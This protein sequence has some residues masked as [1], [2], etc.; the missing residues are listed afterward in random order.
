MQD[1]W[2]VG[3]TF[4]SF[5]SNFFT[6]PFHYFQI[7]NLVDCLTGFCSVL[8]RQAHG[9]EFAN[10]IVSP[11]IRRISLAYFKFVFPTCWV[12]QLKTSQCLWSN[13]HCCRSQ[14]PH[15]LRRGSEAGRLLGLRVRIPPGRRCLSLVNVLCCQ[16][17]VSATGR[18]V[19]QGSPTHWFFWVWSGTAI[20]NE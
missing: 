9:S 19:V 15:G 4:G 12:S 17:E 11:R 3:K 13:S 7:V 8:P 1:L 18:S 16:L 20:Y 2:V 10:F 14:W 5:P 6:Q